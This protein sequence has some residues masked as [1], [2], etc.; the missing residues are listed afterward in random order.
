MKKRKKGG[1]EEK[2]SAP[3]RRGKTIL[4]LC[5]ATLMNVPLETDGG[6]KG[7]EKGERER[8]G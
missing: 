2:N 6:R 7:E 5:Y 3:R 8:E 1:G 4:Q